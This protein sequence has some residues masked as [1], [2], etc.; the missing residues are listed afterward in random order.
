MLFKMNALI[1]FHLFALKKKAKCIFLICF[2]I[3]TILEVRRAKNLIQNKF[4]F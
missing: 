1:Y 3:F 4:S 2:D